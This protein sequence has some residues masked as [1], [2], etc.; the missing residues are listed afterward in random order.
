MKNILVHLDDGEQSPARLRLALDLAAAAQ[1][2]PAG[3]FAHLAAP[4]RV[5]VVATWPSDAYR[6]AAQASA[7]A[8]AAATIGQTRARWFD[9]NR[10]STAAIGEVV[11]ALARCFDLTVLGLPADEHS[12]TPAIAAAVVAGSGRPV[13]VLPCAGTDRAIGRTPLLVWDDSPAAARAFAAAL[14]LL[15]RRTTPTVMI[16]TKGE[17]DPD[18]TRAVIDHLSDHG[19]DVRVEHVPLGQSA[20]DDLILNRAADLGADLVVAGWSDAHGPALLSHLTVPVLL[21]G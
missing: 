9:A 6:A 21:A 17:V 10:G 1:A 15:D 18:K 2:R 3:V 4:Q 5:G 16:L 11:G 14:P 19:L 12:P 20:V 7:A 13:L 8:F